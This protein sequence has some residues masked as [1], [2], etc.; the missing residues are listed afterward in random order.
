MMI[1]KILH[2]LEILTQMQ[3]FKDSLYTY[4]K[5]NLQVSTLLLPINMRIYIAGVWEC[6]ISSI[7]VFKFLWFS[8][9]YV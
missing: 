2:F 1:K 6:L 3:L 7:S 9:Y 8:T 5:E 4:E